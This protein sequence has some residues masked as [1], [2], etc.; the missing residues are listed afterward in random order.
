MYILQSV[1]HFGGATYP[2]TMNI[3]QKKG[4]LI[5]GM[6]SYASKTCE[7]RLNKLLTSQ[8]TQV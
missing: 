7:F 5:C 1:V 6:F 4:L 8:E 3:I 2:H